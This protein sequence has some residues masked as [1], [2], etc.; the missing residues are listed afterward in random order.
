MT[1]L[2]E[3]HGGLSVDRDQLLDAWLARLGPASSALDAGHFDADGWTRLQVTTGRE[4]DLD[5]GGRHMAGRATGVDPQTGSLLVQIDGRATTID[6]GEVL[7][8]RVLAAS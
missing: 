2:R 8:C 6:S 4:V 5:L 3:L 1:S 7:R